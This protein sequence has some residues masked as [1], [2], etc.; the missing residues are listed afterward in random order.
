MTGKKEIKKYCSGIDCL[1]CG[2]TEPC[3][4]RIANELQ[5]QLKHKEEECEKLYIQLKT[6][7]EYH[8]EEENTLRKIIKN[9]EER[10][11]EL[12]KENKKYKQA[13]DEIEINISKYQ[14]LTFDKPR[15]MRENDCIYKILDISTKRRSS[16]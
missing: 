16:K 14:E 7:E 13:L 15:T 5:E 9:K 6:D 8:K 3:I 4:Y 10:N 12:Y 2:E 11:I 1:T